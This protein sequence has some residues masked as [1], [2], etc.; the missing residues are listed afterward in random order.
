MAERYLTLYDYGTG[1]VWTFIIAPSP[2]AI[3][4]KYPQLQI[5]SEPPEWM[6]ESGIEEI[7]TVSLDDADDPFLAALRRS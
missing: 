6:V 2:E 1:G 7:N 4:E 5:V 3:T